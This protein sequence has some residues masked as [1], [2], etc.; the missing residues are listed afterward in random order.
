MS[1][2]NDA[3]Y[4]GILSPDND[5]VSFLFENELL[6]M[7][8]WHLM[9][10]WCIVTVRYR[11]HVFF[12]LNTSPTEGDG[13]LCFRR[14]R[15][16]GWYICLWTTSWRQFKSHCQQTW[17]ILP[18][19]TGDEV[20]KFWKVNIKVGWGV[21]TLL[22]PLLVWHLVWYVVAQPV[23]WWHCWFVVRQVVWSL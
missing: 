18:L 16:V 22:N 9:L 21:C 3:F 12:S 17:S 19:T 15:Y 14:R 5:S 10:S 1:F 20:I 6:V 8:I 7:P 23:L 2:K 13:R 11:S 4:D